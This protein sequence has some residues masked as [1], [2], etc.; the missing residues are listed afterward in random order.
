MVLLNPVKL[1]TVV[2]AVTAPEPLE[3]VPSR[4]LTKFAVRELEHVTRDPDVMPAT[5]VTSTLSEREVFPAFKD[6]SEDFAM[7]PPAKE[8]SPLPPVKQLSN[9]FIK[10]I[11]KF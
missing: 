5:T 6:H 2:S 9:F 4:E 1:A 3:L 11:I 10:T 8:T 7:V